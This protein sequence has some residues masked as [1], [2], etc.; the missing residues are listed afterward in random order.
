MKLGENQVMDTRGKDRKSEMKL[1]VQIKLADL[2]ARRSEIQCRTEI[3]NTMVQLHIQTFTLIIGVFFTLLAGKILGLP[4]SVASWL[5][6]LIPVESSMFGLMYAEHGNTIKNIG[7]YIK[8]EIEEKLLIEKFDWETHIIKLEK[9]MTW[10]GGF[11]RKRA[12]LARIVQK[13]RIPAFLIFIGP[14]LI[15]M[16][17]AGVLIAV[18]IPSANP[19]GGSG[20]YGGVE[21]WLPALLWLV[22]VDGWL[23]Y[24]LIRSLWRLYDRMW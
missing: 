22:I 11:V 24:H 9:V 21:N 18:S 2:A 23:C 20:L 12:P 16:V 8:E 10:E 4:S 3:Q 7:N 13:F 19:L 6:L 14:A 15:T 17:V 5:L 1:Y